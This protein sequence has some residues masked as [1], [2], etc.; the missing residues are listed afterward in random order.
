MSKH[1]D[2][3]DET[4]TDLAKQIHDFVTSI[5]PDIG[6]SEVDMVYCIGLVMAKVQSDVDLSHEILDECY[7]MAD[8]LLG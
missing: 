2:T 5:T 3:V 8:E 7:T 4:V 1:E 6:F